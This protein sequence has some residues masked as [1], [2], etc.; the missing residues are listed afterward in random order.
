MLQKDYFVCSR[1]LNT[2]FTE[3]EDWMNICYFFPEIYSNLICI[4]IP[5]LNDFLTDTE[6]FPSLS[7]ISCCP[8]P[9]PT[10]LTETC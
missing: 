7:S 2:Y 1:T 6:Q 5:M 4:V 10:I 9:D 8:T 3:V